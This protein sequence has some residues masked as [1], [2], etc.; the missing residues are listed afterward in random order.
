MDPL[1][2]DLKSKDLDLRIQG[3]FIGPF[4][5]TDDIRTTTT[6]PDNTAEKVKT[7]A[8]S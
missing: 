7:V 5:H 1:L 3:L 8:S 4:A 6:N 2:A